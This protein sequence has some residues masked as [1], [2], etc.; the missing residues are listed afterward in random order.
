[1]LSLSKWSIAPG[2]SQMRFSTTDYLKNIWIEWMLTRVPS[3]WIVFFFIY[4]CIDQELHI[5][6]AEILHSF[7]I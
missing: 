4:K 7:H 5:I 1:M 2:I 6:Y 3:F